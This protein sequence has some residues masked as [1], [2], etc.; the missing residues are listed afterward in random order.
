M[1]FWNDLVNTNEPFFII[2]T[3]CIVWFTSE[4]ALRFAACPD[5]IVFFKN[6]MNIIDLVAIIP[7]YVTD[8][9][10]QTDPCC[11]GNDNLGKLTENWL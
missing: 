1:T 11:H 8:S 5:H 2:E 10:V 9:T 3:V 4:F 7:Y 6:L